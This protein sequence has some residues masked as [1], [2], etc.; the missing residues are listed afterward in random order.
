M[1]NR[2]AKQILRE[3]VGQRY[4]HTGC[5]ESNCSWYSESTLLGPGRC[6]SSENCQFEKPF[7]LY[8]PDDGTLLRM[9]NGEYY[10]R[11]CKGWLKDGHMDLDCD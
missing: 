1:T 10:C 5:V 2:E 6:C 11:S 3:L 8:C 9:D 4:E 7:C